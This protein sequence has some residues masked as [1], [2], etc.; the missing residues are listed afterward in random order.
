[1]GLFDSVMADCPNCGAKLEFQSKAGECY[2]NVYSVED[3]PD[4]VVR[5]VLNRPEYCRHCEKWSCLYDPDYPPEFPPRPTPKM[6]KVREPSEPLI[7]ETQPYLRWWNARF[8][9]E[10][11]VTDNESPP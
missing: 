8:T 9:S 5:D 1:M 11:I 10:D 6:V 7:H 3:A 4:D 2:M